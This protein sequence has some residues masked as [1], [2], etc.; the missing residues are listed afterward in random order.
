M[1]S[2]GGGGPSIIAAYAVIRNFLRPGRT[3]HDDE[4]AAL[5]AE[6]LREVQY[7]SMGLP[8]PEDRHRPTARFAFL[9]RLLGR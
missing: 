8:V 6:E 3:E 4:R 9:R 1:S 5:D 7:T 2:S